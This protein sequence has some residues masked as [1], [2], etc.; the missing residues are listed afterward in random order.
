MEKQISAGWNGLEDKLFQSLYVIARRKPGVSVEQAGTDTNF[1]FKQLLY[2][3]VGAKPGADRVRAIR[4]A[5]V[6]LTSAASGLPGLRTGFSSPLKILMALVGLVLAIACANVANLLLAR[7]AARQREIAV[8]MSLGAGRGRL[9][10]QL[11]VESGLLGIGGAAAGALFAWTGSHLLLAAV[12]PA[13]QP[14]SIHIAADARVMGFALAITLL[15]VMLFGVAPAFCTT[16]VEFAPVLKEGRGTIAVPSRSRISRALVIGQVALSLVLLAGAGLFLRSFLNLMNVNTGFDKANVLI[17]GIDP[18]AA[19]YRVDTRLENMMNEI[20]DR[21][22]SLSGVSSASFAFMIFGGGWT[23]PV[24]VPGR[25]KTE[26]DPDVFHDIVGARFLNVMKTPIVMGRP[27]TSRDSAISSKVAV[28]NEAMARAYFPGVFPIGRTFSVGPEGEWQ[29]VEVV[30]LVQDAKYMNLGETA[31][32]AAFYPHAQHGMFLYNFLVRFKGDPAAVMPQIRRSI[33]DVDPNLETGEASTLAELVDGSVR[34]QR[35]VA[36]LSTF[37]GVLAALLACIGIYGVVSY[38]VARR[39]NEF[40]IRMAL[41]A[42]RRDVLWTVVRDVLRMV[43]VGI[44]IGAP[45]PVAV[46][47]SPMIRSQL[48]G[49]KSYDPLTIGAALACMVVVALFAGYLP[50]RRAT[51]VDPLSALRYE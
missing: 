14:L 37:F 13:G 15:T 42:A 17:I 8:R 32:P 2:A 50:A 36:E 30:G 35:L 23:Q 5:H 9:I 1:L 4:R 20:E 12:A 43:L 51:R 16:S 39:T 19:G 41:G 21:V 47:L 29:N 10:R 3:W 25:P 44:T 34:N 40:G 48:Y 45:F 26:N 49:L 18:N 22:N 33:R 7:G 6:E 24:T 28:I 31:M 11:L 38:G 46:S 27:L